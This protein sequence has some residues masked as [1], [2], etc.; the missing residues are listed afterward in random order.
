MLDYNPATDRMYLADGNHRV[1]IADLLGIKAIPVVGGVTSKPPSSAGV[2]GGQPPAPVALGGDG[3]PEFVR[4]SDLGLPVV[5]RF[6]PGDGDGSAL[7]PAPVGQRSPFTVEAEQD[8]ENRRI[9]QDA[10]MRCS[11]LAS[12]ILPRSFTR[13][14]MVIPA[15][16]RSSGGS[17]SLIP[18]RHNRIGPEAGPVTLRPP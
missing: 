2:G 8:A 15:P 10:A 4:P 17:A 9:M 6:A 18:S 12:W 16:A 11:G 7:A 13:S 14:R 3:N 5:G 1:K